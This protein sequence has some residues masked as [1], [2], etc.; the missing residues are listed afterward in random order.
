MAVI[1]LNHLQVRRYKTR[2]DWRKGLL[3]QWQQVIRAE[4]WPYVLELFSLLTSTSS[5]FSAS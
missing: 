2:R 4:P 1:E 3:R 5:T